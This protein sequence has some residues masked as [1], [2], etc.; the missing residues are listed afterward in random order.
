M[1]QPFKWQRTCKPVL[2]DNRE[3]AFP[4][5][6]VT[7][8]TWIALSMPPELSRALGLRFPSL[9]DY[10]AH[11]DCV[12][13]A[14]GI[15]PRTWIAFSKP[16]GLSRALG[17]RIPCLR[18]YPAHLVCAF[19]ASGGTTVALS[20]VRRSV[21]VHRSA[22]QCRWEKA[23]PQSSAMGPPMMRPVQTVEYLSREE[24]EILK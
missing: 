21:R 12:F 20:L 5:P 22:E 9:R 23:S 6:V 2:A 24:P 7:T 1:A 19:L 14:S 18:N 10:S 11:L 4:A 17:L 8:G 3:R 15:I 16:P 13:Q